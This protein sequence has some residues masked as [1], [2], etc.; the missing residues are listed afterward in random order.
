M[1]VHSSL[2]D[3]GVRSHGDGPDLPFEAALEAQPLLV[4]LHS[5]QKDSC[6]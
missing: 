6:R 2:V 1:Q 4:A 3:V 5:T